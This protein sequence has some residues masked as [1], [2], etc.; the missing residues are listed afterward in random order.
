MNIIN[1]MLYSTMYRENIQ[2][3]TKIML[4]EIEES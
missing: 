3:I 2:S 4:G 1:N